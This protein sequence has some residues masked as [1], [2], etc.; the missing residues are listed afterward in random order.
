MD[1]SL[2]VVS[3]SGPRRRTRPRPGARFSRHP[4]PLGEGQPC[5][6]AATV[7]VRTQEAIQ[8][9]KGAARATS[10]P[11]TPLTAPALVQSARAS[12]PPFSLSSPVPLPPRAARTL[13]QGFAP[14]SEGGGQGPI[15]MALD[16]PRLRPRQAASRDALDKPLREKRPSTD[17]G[18]APMFR[19]PAAPIYV[20][21]S[22]R[23]DFRAPSPRARTGSRALGGASWEGG[24]GGRDGT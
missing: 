23:A 12:P 8:V 1:H 21:T 13:R 2:A 20:P 7:N 9:L 22:R 14:R 19:H 15:P 10:P 11:P 16:G 5:D 18:C 6:V 17:R 4:R 24:T 3:G